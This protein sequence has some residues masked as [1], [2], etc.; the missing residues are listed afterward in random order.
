[1]GFVIGNGLLKSLSD[2]PVGISPR[3]MKL[4]IPLSIHQ[5]ATLLSFYAPTLT[6]NEER[7][8]EFYRSLNEESRAAISADKVIMLGD[9]N[10]LVGRKCMAWSNVL[11]QHGLGNLNPNG[12]RLLT[13]CAQNEILITN[14]LFQLKDIHKGT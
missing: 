5:Y 6:A 11:G 8:F 10:A 9:F 3:L 14:T 1:M 12:H 7:K 13:I 4:R 2:N